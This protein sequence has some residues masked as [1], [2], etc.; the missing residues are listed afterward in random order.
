M[1]NLLRLDTESEARDYLR[2][3]LNRTVK[4]EGGR[5]E[6]PE[7]NTWV[8]YDYYGKEACKYWVDDAGH[9]L[10]YLDQIADDIRRLRDKMIEIGQKLD[11]GYFSMNVIERVGG[12]CD[13]GIEACALDYEKELVASFPYRNYDAPEDQLIK[14]AAYEH[15]RNTGGL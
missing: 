6:H 10:P 7:S 5:W 3:F 2:D 14:F 15:A 4:D 11:L 1:V 12:K 8:R 13:F 9:D